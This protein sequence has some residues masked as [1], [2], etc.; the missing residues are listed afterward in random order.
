LLQGLRKLKYLAKANMLGSAIGLA[1]SLPLYYYWRIDGIVPAIIITAIFT[2]GIVWYF[3]RKVKIEKV[4]VSLKD[5]KVQAKGMLL[6]GFMLSLSGLIEMGIGY[7]IRIFI[8]NTGGINDVGFFNAGFAIITTYVGLVFTAMATDYYPRLSGVAA[9]N[10]KATLMINQQADIAILILA[11]VLCVFL[12][13][14][15]WIVILLYSTEF[16]PVDEMIHWM[17]LGMFFKAA[18]WSIAFILLAKGASKLYFYNELISHAYML[19]LN[20]LGYYFLGL[21]GLGIS[22]LIAYFLYFIQLLVL[23]GYFYQFKF[24][25]AFYRIFGVQFLLALLCFILIKFVIIGWAYSLGL[26]FIFISGL[27]SVKELDRRLDLKGILNNYR[28]K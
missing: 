10:K 15:N 11:P 24:T 23:A 28:N 17:A 21:E 14:I 27:Y 4:K 7:V 20:L 18:S 8:S 26:L 16:T 2:L 5:T 1:I 6:M 25:S 9:D 19:G 13:F 12:I 22:F 3:S